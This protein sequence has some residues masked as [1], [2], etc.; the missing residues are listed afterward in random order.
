M[1]VLFFGELASLCTNEIELING[2]T[3]LED[4]LQSLK[5]K[6]PILISKN[7]IVAINKKVVENALLNNDDEI[8]L[9]PPF[10]GG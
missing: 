4:V 9:M 8:A 2:C 5:E 1:R 3:T 7:Y 10:S 6:Y